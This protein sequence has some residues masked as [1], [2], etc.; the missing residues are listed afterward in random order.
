MRRRKL[1]VALAGLTV[2]VAAGAVA[3]WSRADRV[4][5]DNV[6]RIR[7]GMSREE[8]GAILG[9]P[10]DYRA[11]PT[12]ERQRLWPDFH[13]A[14]EVPRSGGDASAGNLSFEREDWT[15]DSG[16]A[17]IFFGRE[18]V[19]NVVFNAADPVPL[20]PFEKVFWRLKR[21]W[22]RWFPE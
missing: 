21:Q 16:N 22:R 9:P 17:L 1:L 2:V 11:G 10:G 5:R 19:I 20:G 7:K 12:E 4:T 8:V 6:G 15:G 14:D 3:L 18:G 13:W